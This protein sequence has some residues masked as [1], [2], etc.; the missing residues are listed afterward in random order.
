MRVEV[1]RAPDRTN[2]RMV[3]IRGFLFLS[4]RY[5]MGK[6]C[7]PESDVL[8]DADRLTPDHPP[9]FRLLFRLGYQPGNGPTKHTL[10]QARHGRG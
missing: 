7:E 9:P 10:G 8:C 4:N 5:A 2:V 6:G 1:S 3:L